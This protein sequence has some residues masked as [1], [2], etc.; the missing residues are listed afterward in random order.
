MQANDP[1]PVP[2]RPAPPFPPQPQEPPGTEGSLCPKADHGAASYQGHGRLTGKAALITGGDSGIGKAVAI[3]FAREGADVLLSFLDEQEEEDAVDTARWIHETGRKAVL[4]PGD[5]GRP[6]HC[7]ELVRRAVEA[8]GGIDILVNNAAT[9]TAYPDLASIPEEAFEETFRTNLFS[10]FYLVKAALP[11][12]RRG[13]SI[14]NTASIEAFLPQPAL[15][16]YSSTKG[17]VVTFTKALAGSLA[18]CGI[19]VNA[20]APGPVW[21][22]LI[23]SSFPDGKVA[24]FG[25][26]TPMGRPAQPAELAPIYVLLASDEASYMSG[27]IHEVTGGRALT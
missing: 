6:S 5:I 1:A 14:I 17:A 12:L 4:V 24:A 19:R 22:P 10:M 7:R 9:Q 15:L 23:P 21:T 25:T 8:F 11:H 3:A 27:G 18:G 26:S 20:V 16:P 13:A 2:G